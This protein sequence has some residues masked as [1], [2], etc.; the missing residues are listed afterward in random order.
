MKADADIFHDHDEDRGDLRPHDDAEQFVHNKFGCSLGKH[1]VKL[2]GLLNKD[3]S[4]LFVHSR[5]FKR[6]TEVLNASFKES[7]LPLSEN[8][9]SK[10][11]RASYDFYRFLKITL[12][13]KRIKLKTC[14]I[15]VSYHLLR[16]E[17]QTEL[18]DL[19]FVVNIFF[20]GKPY[21]KST[22]SI[23]LT[24]FKKNFSTIQSWAYEKKLFSLVSLVIQ[25]FHQST[26][27][28]VNLTEFLPKYKQFLKRFIGFSEGLTLALK[29]KKIKNVASGLAYI[30]VRL[31]HQI[32][33]TVKDFVMIITGDAVSDGKPA[34]ELV[35]AQ[36][37]LIKTVCYNSVTNVYLKVLCFFQRYF[38]ENI[39]QNKAL[40]SKVVS[41][42]SNLKRNVM[43]LRVMADD[44]GQMKKNFQILLK[45]CFAVKQ[46]SEN[47]NNSL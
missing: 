32:D 46:V 33:I 14:F 9:K 4:S 20:K 42:R 43:L 27:G 35:K 6:Y 37:R 44:V 11:V 8:I 13:A 2:M 16:L 36:T 47:E 22:L 7:N 29:T 30:I 17:L 5:I 1:D 21:R 24:M 23:Y 25:K 10:I 28:C 40:F 41:K 26:E 18:L 31:F 19:D 45:V 15:C 38:Q 12:K 39:I 3:Y 34:F